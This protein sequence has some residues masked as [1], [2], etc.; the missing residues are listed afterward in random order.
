MHVGVHARD[1]VASAGV[2]MR[3]VR[4]ARVGAVGEGAAGGHKRPEQQGAA[5]WSEMGEN[6][7]M[8][9]ALRECGVR[10]LHLAAAGGGAA[11]VIFSLSDVPFLGARTRWC[12]RQHARQHTYNTYSAYIHIHTDPTC[13]VSAGPAYLISA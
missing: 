10:V 6:K 12:V 7:H 1:T 4:A 3:A 5:T 11:L 2:R 9:G 13:T 8:S